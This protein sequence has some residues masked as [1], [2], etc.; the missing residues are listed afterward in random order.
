[1]VK[2]SKCERCGVLNVVSSE[3]RPDVSALASLDM[4]SIN[5]STVHD[6]C[7]ANTAV[8]RLKAE[9]FLGIGLPHIPIHRSAVGYNSGH[10]LN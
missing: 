5:H 4:G 3:K 10:L 1:M 7:D 9:P 8:E 2:R 6:L